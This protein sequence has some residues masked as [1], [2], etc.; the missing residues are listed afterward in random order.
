MGLLQT[1]VKD[2]NEI[3]VTVN[4]I[5]NIFAELVQAGSLDE[6]KLKTWVY[7]HSVSGSTDKPRIAKL[8][9]SSVYYYFDDIPALRELSGVD[10]WDWASFVWILAFNEK[11]K[12]LVPVGRGL[13]STK[14]RQLAREQWGGLTTGAGMGS[15]VGSASA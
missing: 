7:G 13:L 15:G 11:E 9:S 1:D 5:A 14:K 4:K 10:N 6:S 8:R 12:C 3:S 2:P